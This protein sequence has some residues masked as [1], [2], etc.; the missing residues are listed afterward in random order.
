MEEPVVVL[1][2]VINSRYGDLWRSGR[3][4]SPKGRCRKIVQRLSGEVNMKL[5][6]IP[7]EFYNFQVPLSK[8]NVK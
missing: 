6:I 3:C 8:N 7:Y 5:Q 2:G 4:G 1:D